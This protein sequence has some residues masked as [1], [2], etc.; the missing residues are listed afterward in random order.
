MAKRKKMNN[1]V[2]KHCNTYNKSKVFTDRRKSFKKGY[3]KHKG[4]D[5]NP[6]FLSIKKSIHNV[7]CLI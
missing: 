7:D 2:A 6:Y 4:S 5:K 1:P 3:I